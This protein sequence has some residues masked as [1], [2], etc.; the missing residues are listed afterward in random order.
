MKIYVVVRHHKI[1]STSV[2]EVAYK[3]E[4][5]ANE[6]ADDLRDSDDAYAF[7]VEEI[8]LYMGDR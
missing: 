6:E 7:S 8:D 3:S 1:I 4:Q 2:L 5:R